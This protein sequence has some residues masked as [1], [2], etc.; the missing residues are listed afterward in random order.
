MPQGKLARRLAMQRHPTHAHLYLVRHAQPDFM[1]HYDSVTE[2]GLRQSAWLGSTSRRGL[3]FDRTVCGTLARQSA[4]LET[5]LLHL[6][7]RRR[8]SSTRDSTSTTPP[9]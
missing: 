4:T 5:L 3:Q 7:G 1:G 9:A 8:R 2:L 6:P